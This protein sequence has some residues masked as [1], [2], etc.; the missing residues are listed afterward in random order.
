MALEEESVDIAVRRVESRGNS[1]AIDRRRSGM[2]RRESSR[3]ALSFLPS[4]RRVSF[5]P[6]HP[7]LHCATH[8]AERRLPAAGSQSTEK[9]KAVV[10]AELLVR[11]EHVIDCSG[12]HGA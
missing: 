9:R 10:R 4:S 12:S 2:D 6:P 5:T 8:A 7:L 1:C 11:P 3:H